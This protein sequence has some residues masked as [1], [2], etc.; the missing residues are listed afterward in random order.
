MTKETVDFSLRI[1][2][3]DTCNFSC[4][5]CPRDTGMENFCPHSTRNN[6][7]N[8]TSFI[9]AINSLLEKYC[10]SKVVVTGGEPLLAKDLPQIL[11]A[12]K[13]HNQYLELDTNGSLFSEVLWEKIKKFPDAVKVSFDSLNKT[14]FNYLTNCKT[15]NGFENT[16][17]LIEACI[18]D[19]I[20]ITLNIVGTKQNI[21]DVMEIVNFAK[22]K[23]INTSLLD[24]YYTKETHNFWLDN[25]VSV[26]QWVNDNKN[27]FDSIE[28]MDD[29]GCGFI[30][31]YYN[32]GKNYL[33]VKLSEAKT[34]RDE[35]CINCPDYCQEGI[36]ALRLS[37]QGWLTPCQSNNGLGAYYTETSKIQTLIERINKTTPSTDSFD[38][39]IKFYNL[40]TPTK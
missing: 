15:P 9:E 13:E 6:R 4:L 35:H 26:K 37:R 39:L 19:R 23:Q 30:K 24:L 14:K 12:I 5:Y 3:I 29:F 40:K 22:T 8:T 16:R 28:T 34:M 38:K 7:L 33:R 20:P 17:K 10:F 31:M 36:F 2:V 27:S 21:Q 18:D 1:A 25:Y 11:Q 32:A